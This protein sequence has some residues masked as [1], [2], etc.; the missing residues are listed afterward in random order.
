[1]GLDVVKTFAALALVL[2]LIFVLAWAYRRYMPTGVAGVKDRKGWRLLG[3]R[4]LA[5][6]KQVFVLEV[7]SKL[8][9]IGTAD[10][11]ITPLMEVSDKGDC[12]LIEDALAS[13]PPVPFSE[14]LKRAKS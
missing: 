5:P 9:L 2:G 8:L 10:K 12:E 3:V 14:F 7:G 13:K 1:M 11:Q 6:G 4:V